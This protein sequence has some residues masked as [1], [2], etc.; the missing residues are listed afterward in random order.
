MIFF[1]EK[2]QHYLKQYTDIRDTK[3]TILMGKD[4]KNMSENEKNQYSEK[5]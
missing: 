5:Y 1:N 4:W 2:R 3:L